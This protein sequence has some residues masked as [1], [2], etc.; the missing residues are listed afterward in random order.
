MPAKKKKPRPRRGKF[1]NHENPV[2]EPLLSLAR[3]YIDE[4]MWMG[5]VELR[6]GT[7]IQAYKHYWTRRYLYLANDGRAFFYRADLYHEERQESSYQEL[8]E[9]ELREVFD[10]VVQRRDPAL[11]IPGY[12]ECHGEGDGLDA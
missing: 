2:W 1:V 3:I 8:P 5:E 7:R 10:R 11:G 6:D 9:E 12:T 4:F